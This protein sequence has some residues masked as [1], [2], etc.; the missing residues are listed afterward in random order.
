MTICASQ[1]SPLNNPQNQPLQ[2]LAINASEQTAIAQ[3]QDRI[4]QT[5]PLNAGGRVSLNNINGTVVIEAWNKA[6]AHVE[7]IKTIDCDKPF[8]IDVNIDSNPSSLEIETDFQR[9]NSG[10]GW[11]N[12]NRCREARVDYKLTL[13]RNARLDAIETVNGNITLGGM[14]D[15]VKASTVNGRIN[16]SNLRGTIN[17]SSVNGTLAADFENLDNVREVKLG[18]VNGKIDLQLPSDIEATLKA[19]TVNGAINNDFGLPVH[20]GEYVGRNLYGRL[21]SGGITVKLD[22]VNGTINIRRKQDGRNPKQV[23]NLLP[24]KGKDVDDDD[25]DED[26]DDD[27]GMAVRAPKTPRAAIQPRL[28]RQAVI[29]PEV[30]MPPGPVIDAKTRQEIRVSVAEATKAAAKVKIDQKEL[31]RQIREG[32]ANAREQ[33]AE[34][35]EFSFSWNNGSEFAPM[36]ERETKTLAV[37]GTPRVTVEAQ[38]GTVSVR[39]WDRAEVSYAVGRQSVNGGRE[40]AKAIVTFEKKGSDV[41]V[42]VPKNAA[43]YRL[44]IYVPRNCNL[45]VTSSQQIRVEGVKGKL[46]LDGGEESVDV[47]DSSGN[48]S[49]STDDGRVRIIG[50]DGATEV[51]TLNGDIALEGDFS[52]LDT[53]TVGGMTSL[54][55]NDGVAAEIQ[56]STKDVSFDGVN[57]S[58]SPA[59]DASTNVWRIGGKDAGSKKYCLKTNEGKIVVRNL[60]RVRVARNEATWF[61]A[62]G[63]IY[64]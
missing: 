32:L 49:V 36:R 29:A 21:G 17:L 35:R 61:C 23:T 53:D 5:Y 48:L 19:D 1:T 10:R 44:E 34:A 33:M 24:A 15:F 13:P 55:L 62:E 46:N 12:N 39:G 30:I 45:R 16:A 41:N 37:E 25:D 28:P 54:V 38:G 4:D 6:E 52:T 50:F 58:S 59:S 60:N 22:G 11:N 63:E 26:K 7:A 9:E 20:K 2:A 57:V 51:K 47:R 31:N 14:T 8:Q 3:Q 43:N 40:S 56:S 18:M 42:L 27:D 64:S